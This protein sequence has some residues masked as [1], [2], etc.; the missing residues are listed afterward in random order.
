MKSILFISLIFFGFQGFSQEF[1]K[2]KIND[3]IIVSSN[4][5]ETRKMLQG[6]YNLL[7]IIENGENFQIKKL[8]R[9]KKE[10][11]YKYYSYREN[12]EDNKEEDEEIEIIDIPITK[13]IDSIKLPERDIG[14]GNFSKGKKKLQV[15]VDPNQMLNMP[16]YTDVS[17]SI[18]K[19]NGKFKS[20]TEN[21]KNQKGLL[22]KYYSP[23]KELNK[24]FPL[25]IYNSSDSIIKIDT[26]EGWLFIIQEAL[27]LDGKWKPIEYHDY[28][29]VCGN[30]YGTQFL[31]PG[32]SI[33]TKIYVYNGDFQTK[34]RVKLMT[35]NQVYYS[36]EFIGSINRGQFIIPLRYLKKSVKEIKRMFFTVE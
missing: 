3:S 15:F 20:Y 11:W 16:I 35:N 5:L 21:D 26:Q 17:T 8:N 10:Y 4:S 33:I 14:F 24:A 23:E 1:L 2:S 22:K 9:K 28:E 31:I 29:A 36:N 32:F 27:D 30:S 34:L 25:F 18:E 6:G 19:L 12:L 7:G 13:I